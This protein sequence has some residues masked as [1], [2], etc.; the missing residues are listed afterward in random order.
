MWGRHTMA[1]G[2]IYSWWGYEDMLGMID[3]IWDMAKQLRLFWD[4]LKAIELSY[5]KFEVMW[6]ILWH[7]RGDR[8]KFQSIWELFVT[9][10]SRL[11]QLRHVWNDMRHTMT[12]HIRSGWVSWHL[13]G[14][15]AIWDTLNWIWVE[16]SDVEA[17]EW[18]LS[19]SKCKSSKMYDLLWVRHIYCKLGTVLG[20][21]LTTGEEWWHFYF[22]LEGRRR[23]RDVLITNLQTWYQ[24]MNWKQRKYIWDKCEVVGRQ[25]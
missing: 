12:S 3:T 14:F 7:L 15:E 16:F 5:D 6:D 24:I 10:W 11:R 1:P 22:A 2:S 9:N 23:T 25:L 17:R 8:V 21:C 4:E 13:I 18:R 20:H 19:S